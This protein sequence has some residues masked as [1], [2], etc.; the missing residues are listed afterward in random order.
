MFFVDFSPKYY[1]VSADYNEH[2]GLTL[3][4]KSRLIIQRYREEIAKYCEDNQTMLPATAGNDNYYIVLWR[5]LPKTNISDNTEDVLIDQMCRSIAN[6]NNELFDVFIRDLDVL[7]NGSIDTFIRRLCMIKKYTQKK[8]TF[9]DGTTN[10]LLSPKYISDSKED[11]EALARQ[12][13]LASVEYNNM[14]NFMENLYTSINGCY[15]NKDD[16]GFIASYFQWQKGEITAETACKVLGNMSKR[17]FYKYAA[18]FEAHPFYLEHCKIYFSE[19]INKEKKGSISID[20]Q[21]FY[22]EAA[23]LFEEKKIDINS[24]NDIN[25]DHICVKYSLASTLDVYRT[26]LAVKKKLKI[27]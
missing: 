12:T 7:A 1:L 15:V 8:P 21:E 24:F 23:P 20:L 3:Q 17:T 2:E 27:K 18:E 5:N 16:N 9:L 11:I 22:N 14:I 25:T 19:L 26:L 4:E 6:Y 13:Y 10:S